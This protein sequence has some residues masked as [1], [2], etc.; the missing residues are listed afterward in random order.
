MSYKK[1]ETVT[2]FR[3]IK[4][5]DIGGFFITLYRFK[6]G[7]PAYGMTECHCSDLQEGSTCHFC[8]NK[9]MGIRPQYKGALGW[10]FHTAQSD[11]EVLP[12]LH[13]IDE[14]L[15]M[16]GDDLDKGTF[17]SNSLYAG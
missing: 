4:R 6:E 13:P 3:A 10:K 1:D 17:Q 8:I 2:H 15:A 7:Y 11:N 16:T 9:K 5:P 14:L 12:H